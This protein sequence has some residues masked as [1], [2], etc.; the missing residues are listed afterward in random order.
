MK[1]H[2]IDVNTI[3]GAGLLDDARQLVSQAVNLEYEAIR[4]EYLADQ[5]PDLE[6]QALDLRQQADTKM[7]EA[8]AFVKEAGLGDDEVMALKKQFLRSTVMNIEASHLSVAERH[9]IRRDA[10][11]AS[12]ETDNQMAELERSKEIALEMLSDLGVDVAQLKDEP[13][14]QGMLGQ[15]MGQAP[16]PNRETRRANSGKSKKK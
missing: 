14:A 12:P 2:L 1:Y 5:N 9:R 15:P 13:A 11:V 4:V 16:T 8:N 10:G 3:K 7:K 6:L